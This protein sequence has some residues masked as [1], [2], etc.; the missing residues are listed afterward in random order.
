MVLGENGKGGREDVISNNCDINL[1]MQKKK[2]LL[3]TSLIHMHVL[4][5]TVYYRMQR[6]HAYT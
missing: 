3:D 6:A 5:T 1:P 4:C 2:E